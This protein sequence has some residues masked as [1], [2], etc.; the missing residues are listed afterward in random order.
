MPG[1]NRIA[2]IGIANGYS[3]LSPV[4]PPSSAAIEAM[5][6]D[7]DTNTWIAASKTL[8]SGP[9][10]HAQNYQ[11]TD[12][13]DID[14]VLNGTNAGEAVAV[15][16]NAYFVYA[17]V[18]NGATNWGANVV[19]EL[20]RSIFECA[21]PGGVALR[22]LVQRGIAAIPKAGRREHLEE[23]VGIFDFELTDDELERVSAL[24]RGERLVDPGWAPKRD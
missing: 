2:F 11:G 8:L 12:A 6:W 3:S 14:F 7:G 5:V 1:T 17:N 18:W 16:G 24:G 13:A 20:P 15:W 9:I 4:T 22:W 21:P 19:A 10:S 23:N